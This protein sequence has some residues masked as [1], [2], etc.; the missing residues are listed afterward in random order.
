MLLFSSHSF[1]KIINKNLLKKYIL[2]IK[3]WIRC[4]F[5][6]IYIE[7]YII[8]LK[9][10]K[11]KV[12]VTICD[13]KKKACLILFFLLQYKKLFLFKKVVYNSLFI[14]NYIFLV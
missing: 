14:L 8:D 9:C 12:V 11:N 7:L 5:F 13:T 10:F 2:F 3:L 1:P 6:Y 4:I